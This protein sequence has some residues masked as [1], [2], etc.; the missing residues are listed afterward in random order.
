[1]SRAAARAAEQDQLGAIKLTAQSD[2]AVGQNGPNQQQSGDDPNRHDAPSYEYCIQLAQ[3]LRAFYATA[4]LDLLL[5]RMLREQVEPIEIPPEL[6][7]VKTEYH[8]ATATDE[9]QNAQAAIAHA[10]PTLNVVPGEDDDSQDNAELR[11]HFTEQLL[12]DAFDRVDGQDVWTAAVDACLEGG[13]WIKVILDWEQW[14]DVYHLRP[15]D[16]EHDPGY[17]SKP[18][19][20]S[21]ARKYLDRRNSEKHKSHPISLAVCDT[22]SIYPLWEGQNVTE[23]VEH[24]RRPALNTL[25][26]YHLGYDP[27][28]GFYNKLGAPLEARDVRSLGATVDYYECWDD[29]FVTR[30]IWGGGWGMQIEQ[31]EHGL[32]RHPYFYAPGIY[33]N[34]WRQRKVGWGVTKSKQQMLRMKNFIMSL[35]QQET[36]QQVGAPIIHLGGAQAQAITGSTGVPKGPEERYGFNQILNWGRDDDVKEFPVKGI[37]P[38]LAELLKIYGEEIE[39]LTS[40]RFNGDIAGSSVQGAGFAI[41]T[42]LTNDQ[43][44]RAVF[45]DSLKRT[46]KK[47][48]LFI[49]HIITDV[50]GEDVY[51]QHASTTAMGKVS[52]WLKAGPTDLGGAVVFEWEINL[53]QASQDM[54][55]ERTWAER[56]K[57]GS[58]SMDMMI[59]ALGS[60]PSEVRRGRQMDRI[61]QTQWYIDEVD[62]G[63]MQGMLRGDLKRKAAERL[64]ATGQF[65]G[66]ATQGAEP[67]VPNLTPRAGPGSAAVGPPPN[68]GQPMDAGALASAPNGGG[69]GAVP[70][71]GPT[72]IGGGATPGVGQPGQQV[73]QQLQQAGRQLVSA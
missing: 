73:A 2:G 46:L 54:I 41:S 71:P 47:L 26:R 40:P 23:V 36:A 49:W 21:R 58:A 15:G 4:D 34:A 52:R 55:L 32:G 10:R 7:R 39:K 6:L 14:A 43:L 13:A 3:R 42:I 70:R 51:V 8:D 12:Y 56:V 33:S 65:P 57:N 31:Q 30:L 53:K 61:R 16:F 63:V 17:P 50:V 68:A 1:M 45:I 69:I 72:Q 19:T 64:A 18:G 35:I 24:T 28:S 25:N 66:T 38:H 9:H 11:E 48:T 20:K 37:T 29:R 27:K 62:R 60:N 67:L 59:E 22:I 44:R 5:D